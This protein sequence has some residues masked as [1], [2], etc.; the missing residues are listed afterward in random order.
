MIFLPEF[1]SIFTSGINTLKLFYKL[2]FK[3]LLVYLF[4]KKLLE[5][6]L[7]ILYISN[8]YTDLKYYS[9]YYTL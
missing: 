4:I 8:A 3:V 9:G 5:L 2:G 6:A 7:S 1:N